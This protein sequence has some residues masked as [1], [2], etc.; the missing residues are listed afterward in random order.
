M[1]LF[2]KQTLPHVLNGQNQDGWNT[3]KNQMKTTH[4]FYTVFEVLKVLLI[5]ICKMHGATRSFIPCC[6]M[7]DFTSAYIISH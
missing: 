2:I 7:L 6:F 3:N 5:I 1:G 4:P